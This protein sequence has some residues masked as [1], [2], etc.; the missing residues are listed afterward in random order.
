MRQPL[1]DDLRQ[2]LTEDAYDPAMEFWSVTDNE[3]LPK[4]AAGDME[5]ARAAYAKIQ[6]AYGRHRTAIDATVQK[7]NEF[8]AKNRGFGP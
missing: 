4:L 6:E 1:A 3:F 5:G 2:V 7:A 8:V